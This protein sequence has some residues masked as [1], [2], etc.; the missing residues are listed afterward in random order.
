[1]AAGLVEAERRNGNEVWAREAELDSAV[2][3]HGDR[4]RDEARGRHGG[5]GEAVTPSVVGED[6]LVDAP[7][8]VDARVLSF[9]ELA[10]ALRAHATGLYSDEASTELLIEHR[11]WLVRD[12][13]LSCVDVMPSL[14][15]HQVLMA[16]VD[17]AQV[18]AVDLPASTTDTAI[19]AI[20][21][22][23]AGTHSGRTLR[24]LVAG[25][26]R[27]NTTLVVQA[28]LHVAHGPTSPLTVRS[29][30]R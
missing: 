7:D 5:G 26:D 11:A 6:M 20:A 10:A 16:D 4:L 28:V 1:M 14:P 27:A 12:D 3:A 18:S 23:L 15:D 13:F 21:G 29:F 25:L 2:A 30:D 9:D 22:E 24:D 19:L 17:W 8:Q